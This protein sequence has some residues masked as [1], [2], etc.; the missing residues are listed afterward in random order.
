[1]LGIAGGVLLIAALKRLLT[2]GFHLYAFVI[3]ANPTSFILQ[4]RRADKAVDGRRA[5][6]L[7]TQ[8]VVPFRH[9]RK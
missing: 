4:P 2:S 6:W 7:I 8:R 3:P 9:P 1:M 5:V